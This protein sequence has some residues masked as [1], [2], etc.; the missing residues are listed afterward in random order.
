MRTS[1][2][3]RSPLGRQALGAGSRVASADGAMSSDIPGALF[4]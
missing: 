2:S 4:E 3:R 1:Q